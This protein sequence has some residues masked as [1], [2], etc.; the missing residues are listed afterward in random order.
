[1]LVDCQFCQLCEGNRSREPQTT[2]SAWR[3]IM[4][5]QPTQSP[6][7]LHLVQRRNERIEMQCGIIEVASA[8]Y[9][10][11]YGCSMDATAQCFDCFIPLCDA[12]TEHCKLCH[13]TFCA[14]CLGFHKREQ[15]Q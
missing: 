2:L 7:Q 3:R 12:H 11:R 13:E 9:V 14:T 8:D 5:S 1:M 4:T 6:C 15:H 10:V